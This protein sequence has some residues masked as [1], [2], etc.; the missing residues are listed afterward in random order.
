MDYEQLQANAKDEN[1]NLLLAFAVIIAVVAATAAAA[2]TAT[3]W[4]TLR[5]LELYIVSDAASTNRAVADSEL[6]TA[7]A[8]WGWIYLSVFAITAGVIVWV[9]HSRE[10]ALIA[11]GGAGIARSMGGRRV[12]EVTTDSAERRFVNTVEEM[13]I[14]AGQPA[15]AVYVL[16]REHSINAFN[17]GWT[18]DT[19]VIGITNGALVELSR[20]ELQAVAAQAMSHVF[21]G[22]AR[23]NLRLMALVTGVAG[24]A[25]IGEDWI[26]RSKP[27]S[28]REDEALVIPTLV[29]GY[30][31]YG[32]GWIGVWL[33]SSVQRS[34]AKRHELL[35]DATAVELLR[36]MVPVRDAL[37]RIG[38]HPSRGRIRHRRARS[39]NH[40]FMV[41]AGGRR[42]GV[43]PDMRLRVLRL[44]PTWNGDW[45]RNEDGLVRPDGPA[46]VSAEPASP[47]SPAVSSIGMVPALEPLA[48]VF[49]AMSAPIA[50]MTGAIDAG[51]PGGSQVL[52]P[53]MMAAVADEPASPGP[54]VDEVRRMVVALTHLATGRA[55]TKDS[56]PSFCSPDEV[57]V[58]LD[59]LKRAVASDPA[60]VDRVA[61][62]ADAGEALRG[63]EGTEA[64]ARESIVGLRIE[65]DLDQ[66]ILRRL[67]SGSLIDAPAPKKRRSL[68]R[69]RSD[70]AS[71]LSTLVAIG[72]GNTEV[73]FGVAAARADLLGLH[74]LGP[75]KLSSLGKSLDKLAALDPSDHD[76]ALSGLMAA[77]HADGESRRSEVE[78]VEVVRL[79]LRTSE[80]DESP[81][82]P[83]SPKSARSARRSWKS[84]LRSR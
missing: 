41:D 26:D 1:R 57:A 75:G 70:Y 7:R 49:D 40:L 15:P 38:G 8:P 79:T 30:L 35:A 5:A 81:K 72:G 63:Q 47:F 69:L 34:V 18:N 50:G 25:M 37:R 31:L 82:S 33:S 2:V 48:P 45:L 67:I 29:A 54:D 55:P 74:Q 78:F 64:F 76:R 16:D 28:L 71:V 77:V 22:D 36:Q 17:A 20:E 24:L 65:S 43:H 83:K 23:L 73:A 80:P 13:A 84:R 51:P 68:E 27:E 53:V 4:G 46:P 12:T 56:V 62:L 21:H 61:M 52:A 6:L 59:V 44:D 66:W 9:S 32:V 14:A 11:F 60:A 39:A 10:R 19:T 42:G 3:G 58:M